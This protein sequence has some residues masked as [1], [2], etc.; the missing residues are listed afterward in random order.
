MKTWKV[1]K[2]LANHKSDNISR[3]L[4]DKITKICS[5]SIV[6]SWNYR[7]LSMSPVLMFRLNSGQPIAYR[8]IVT[9]Q[10]TQ[11]SVFVD[12]ELSVYSKFMSD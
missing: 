11:E 9:N 5:I 2:K 3:V 4:A 1:I 10:V 8:C 7:G 6:L 12:K